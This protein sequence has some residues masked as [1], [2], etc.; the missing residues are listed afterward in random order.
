MVYYKYKYP[1]KK[2]F[3]IS[4]NL[5]LNSLLKEKMGVSIYKQ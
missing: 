3:K 2:E 5:N 1:P 4:K